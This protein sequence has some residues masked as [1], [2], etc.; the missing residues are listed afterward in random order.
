MQALNTA[1]AMDPEEEGAAKVHMS[2]GLLEDYRA[3]KIQIRNRRE[4]FDTEK[5]EFQPVFKRELWF[6]IL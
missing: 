1:I 5:Q 2:R 4:K 3:F 6:I